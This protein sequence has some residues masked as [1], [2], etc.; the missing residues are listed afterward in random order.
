MAMQNIK[1]TY[2]D[3]LYI[4]IKKTFYKILQIPL[5]SHISDSLKNTTLILKDYLKDTI[6]LS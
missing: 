3:N 6:P 1:T 5:H 4:I 2:F